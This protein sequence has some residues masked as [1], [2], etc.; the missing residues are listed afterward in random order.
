MTG[1]RPHD[2]PPMA[3]PERAPYGIV[4]PDDLVGVRA[5]RT[6]LADLP[7][8]ATK[9]QIAERAGAWRVPITGAH[10]HPLAQ[11]L[12]GVPDRRYRDAGALVRAVGKA[13]PDLTP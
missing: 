10:F 2:E 3:P 6:M 7:F 8:P 5:I 13:H 1:E 11:F 9:R 12:E 4:P